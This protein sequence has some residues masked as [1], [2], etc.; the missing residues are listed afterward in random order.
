MESNE[1]CMSSIETQIGDID[2]AYVPSPYVAD[3]ASTV[4]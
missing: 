1:S 2:F 3:H 4:S